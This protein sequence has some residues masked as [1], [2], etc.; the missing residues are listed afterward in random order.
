MHSFEDAWR[1]VRDKLSAG[2]VA[3]AKES[4][5]L[6]QVY[7]RVLAEDVWADRDYPPFHR[8]TRDGY[9]LR[10]GDVRALPAGLQVRGEIRAGESFAGKVGPGEC[11]RIMTGAPLPAGADAVVM[12]EHVRAWD[13][14]VEV[15]R[16]VGRWENVVSQG[17]EATAG[18]V[19]LPAGRRLG[20]GEMGLLA[21]VGWARTPVFCQPTVAI[22]P[23]GDELV[24]V[25]Q[26]PGNF[27]TRDS[28]SVLLAAQVAAA[29]G[30][31]RSL[32]IAPDQQDSLRRM[33][34]EGSTAELLLLSGGVSVGKY[35]LA[36]QT[37]AD[38][39]AEFYIQGVAMRPGK[40]LVFGRLGRSF[41]FGLPGNPVSAL[42]TF[43]LFARPALA[44]LSGAEFETPVF[45]RARLARPYR[46]SLGLTIFLPAKVGML[47][48]DPV[49]EPVG[50]QGS[51]DLVGLATANCFMVI[52]PQQ[53]EIA[54]GTQVDI[55]LKPA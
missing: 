49:V 42:V 19:V 51:G 5:P 8:A 31:P 26:R 40:P 52:H 10:S 45:L 17:S 3:P 16:E 53:T 55:L 34:E 54:A 2:K 4:L 6:E 44:A 46:Q 25:E 30:I 33:I 50:W 48:S 21:T 38:L 1:I 9:A 47:D 41:F 13:S 20:A 22:L 39:G 28:N 18:S 37:L 35:D 29:G 7:G 24:P 43:Q 12:L 14:Q 15:T 11:V 36:K 23:T 32:G 27:Q